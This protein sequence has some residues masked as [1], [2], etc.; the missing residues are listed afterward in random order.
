MKLTPTMQAAL[1]FARAHDGKLT[2]HPGGFWCGPSG[3]GGYIDESGEYRA[4][5]RWFG[6]STVHALVSR[7]VMQY[8]AWQPS[9]K[10]RPFPIEASVVD[11]KDWKVG[12]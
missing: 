10:H 6:T 5:G 3:V 9:S 11:M 7:G 8:T 2:R 4:H 1:D 12:G